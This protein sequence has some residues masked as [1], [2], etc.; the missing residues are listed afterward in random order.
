MPVIFHYMSKYTEGIVKSVV[1]KFLAT[2]AELALPYILAYLIDEIVPLGNL[3]KVFLWGGLM[4]FMA[5]ATRQFNVVANKLAVYN[6]HRVS[7]DLRQDLFEKTINLSGHQ[8]DL[9][10]LP[11]LISRMTSDSY[12]VQSCVQSLQTMCTRIPILL[13]GGISATLM[14]DPVLASILSAIVPILMIVIFCVSRY[15]I[16]LYQQVQHR[17]DN[18]VRIMREDITGIRVVKA[19]SKAEY[20]KTR[21]RRANDAMTEAD[22]LASTIMAIPGPAMQLCLNVG[23]TLVVWVGAHRVEAGAIKAGVILAFLTYFN[24]VLQGVMGVNRI[25]IMVSKA[26]ASADRIGSV[27]AA[28]EDQTTMPLSEC[29]EPQGD[30]FIRFEHVNFQYRETKTP[31][32]NVF[33]AEEKTQCLTD[34]SFSI[35]K[36]E[37]LGIIG[38]TGCGK[39]TIINLLMRFYDAQEGNVFVDGRDVRSYNKDDLRRKFGVVFQNDIVFFDTLREN[40]RLGRSIDEAAMMRAA[41]DAVAA[42]YIGSLEQGLDHWADIKG[43]NLSGGQKQRLLISRALAG[44]PEILVLDDSSSALDYKTDAVLR[45]AIF[46]H[47]QDTTTIMVAQRV[48][49]IRNMTNILVLD[50]GQCIGYGDHETLMKKCATYREICCAQ[51]GALK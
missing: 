26:T 30:E 4:I 51:M 36:G 39:T 12:N 43:A 24:M 8:Y 15:G 18:V 47:Y 27:L 31:D 6:A 48:S 10:G 1:I 42:E 5:I 19:L 41:A 20:E 7:Y 28:R 25:F 38:P 40:I 34:I 17:L 2:I 46:E 3:N 35:K 50:N 29:P 37:S 11:S 32:L 9:F 45:K 23:L 13:I 21:F 22:V 33:E 44:N 49:S 16:P 14:M